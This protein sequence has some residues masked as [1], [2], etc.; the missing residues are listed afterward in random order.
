MS[1]NLNHFLRALAHAFCEGRLEHV[2]QNFAYPMP[3]YTDTSLLVFGA[4]HSL[5][6]GLALY[7]E[8]VRKAGI[9]RIV[10]RIIANGVPVRGYSNLWVEWD[11]MDANDACVRTSQVRYAILEQ[12]DALAPRIELV[13]YTVSAF[14]ELLTD[15][16]ILQSA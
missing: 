1:R 8:A 2:A 7:H 16:P 15:L 14:P 11:H 12:D 10:P 9:V 4:Q 5:T 6:E 3:F 13:D